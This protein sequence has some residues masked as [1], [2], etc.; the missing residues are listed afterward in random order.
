MTDREA[1]NQEA[2]CGNLWVTCRRIRELAYSFD[3]LTRNLD[4]VGSGLRYFNTK[5]KK[6]RR[7]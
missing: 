7:Q 5:L 2:K 6:M 4:Y 3:Q 1:S